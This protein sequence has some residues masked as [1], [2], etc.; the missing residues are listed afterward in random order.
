M[1]YQVKIVESAEKSLS[2]VPKKDREVIVE[3][4]E[5]LGSDPR[6]LGYIKLKGA[7]KNILYRI[8]HGD[9]RI[10][11][12]VKDDVLIVLVLEIGNR[13]EIYR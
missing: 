10:V 9:Y 6:P 7:S 2:K 8:R 1:K 5:S 4:I 11:Y 3:K 13:K 12:T